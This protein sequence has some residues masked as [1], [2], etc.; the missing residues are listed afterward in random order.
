[1]RG[2]GEF[3]VLALDSVAVGGN[4]VFLSISWPINTSLLRER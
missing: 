1:M 4:L 2:V 3:R